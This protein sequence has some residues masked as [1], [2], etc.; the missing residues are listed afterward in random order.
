M[1]KKAK[2][3]IEYEGDR[4][5]A[6]EMVPL[7]FDGDAIR[8]GG[9]ADSYV[10]ASPGGRVAGVKVCRPTTSDRILAWTLTASLAAAILGLARVRRNRQL[11]DGRMVRLDGVR[12][13]R[14][15][16]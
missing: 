13:R 2:L 8:D 10:I 7:E 4:V 1:T 11:P 9:R 6:F 16:V 14:I 5:E 12:Q 15:P 3:I